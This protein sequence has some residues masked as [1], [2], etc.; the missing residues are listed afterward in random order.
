MKLKDIDRFIFLN[1]SYN[2]YKIAKEIKL[3]GREV[4][5]YKTPEFVISQAYKISLHFDN[6]YLFF[7]NEGGNK[8]ITV[9]DIYKLKKSLFNSGF[10]PRNLSFSKTLKDFCL[11]LAKKI[12]I[13]SNQFDELEELDLTKKILPE[14]FLIVSAYAIGDLANK[15]LVNKLVTI[16]DT[17]KELIESIKNNYFVFFVDSKRYEVFVQGENLVIVGDSNPDFL[18]SKK[19]QFFERFNLNQVKSYV[20]ALNENSYIVNFDKNHILLNDYSYFNISIS[21]PD[22]WYKK[23][24]QFLCTGKV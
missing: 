9:N 17:D 22:M 21:M 14:N 7:T 5:F 19:L 11:S 13:D 24:G 2:M 4:K 23:V 1:P 20:I 16:Y 15:R 3:L 18:I 10:K 8:E 6:R 12:E